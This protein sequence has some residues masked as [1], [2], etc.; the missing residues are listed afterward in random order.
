[1]GIRGTAGSRHPGMEKCNSECDTLWDNV[2]T[3]QRS[4]RKQV[5]KTRAVDLQGQSKAQHY[6]DLGSPW[7]VTVYPR[8]FLTPCPALSLPRQVFRSVS[9]PSLCLTVTSGSLPP[10]RTTFCPLL[11]GAA[12]GG[13]CGSINNTLSRTLG[14]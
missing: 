13:R 3:F 9:L 10:A 1:M 12:M 7:Q 4:F 11:H 8:S 2:V 6:L 5:L 14:F